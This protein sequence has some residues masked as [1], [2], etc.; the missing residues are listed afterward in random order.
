MH[1]YLTKYINE[2]NEFIVESWLQV[3]LFKWSV[4]FSKRQMKIKKPSLDD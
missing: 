4:C 1:H 2:R 3:N